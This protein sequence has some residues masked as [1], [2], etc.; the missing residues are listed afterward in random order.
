MSAVPGNRVTLGRNVLF[1]GR[2]DVPLEASLGALGTADGLLSKCFVI[3][4]A[5]SQQLCAIWWL[6]PWQE[7]GGK[8]MA[9]GYES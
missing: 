8:L 3:I 4:S 7:A 6:F 2:M 5:S 1:E 9:Q